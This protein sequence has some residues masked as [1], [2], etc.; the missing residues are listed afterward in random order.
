MI[1]QLKSGLSPI[2]KLIQDVGTI[3]RGPKAFDQPLFLRKTLEEAQQI[4]KTNSPYIIP[5]IGGD[6][7][8]CRPRLSTNASN[9]CE[10]VLPDPPL[11]SNV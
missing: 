8:G 3:T 7:G 1:R 10:Q 2:K 4:C 9:G 5:N 6:L 11:F